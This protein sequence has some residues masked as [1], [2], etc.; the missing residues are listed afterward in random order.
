[1][2]GPFSRG[3]PGYGERMDGPGRG[4]VPGRRELSE[5]NA[6]DGVRRMPPPI[7]PDPIN[8][9]RNIE[10]VVKLRGLPFEATPAD[11]TDWINGKVRQR[12]VFLTNEV[13]CSRPELKP[14]ACA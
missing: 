2:R 12:E 5:H 8:N 10:A 4:R 14:A 1:V 9:P 13:C 3:A 6:A 7:K 11:V